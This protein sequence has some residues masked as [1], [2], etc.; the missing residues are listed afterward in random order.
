[1]VEGWHI[2]PGDFESF[3]DPWLFEGREI[4]LCHWGTGIGSNRWKEAT[5][6]FLF[7]EFHMP[8]RVHQAEVFALTNQRASLNAL[9]KVQSPNNREAAFVALRD[10]H[11]LRWQKQL[12]M[13]GNARN[14]TPSGVCG[15]QKLVITGEFDR[16]ISNKDV[17]FPGAKLKV[18]RASIQRG[19]KMTG[20]AAV[21]AMLAE[22]KEDVIPSSVVK[23][24]TGVDMGKHGKRIL[25]DA[26]L[27]GVMRELGWTW[28]PTKGGKGH[29]S[30]FRR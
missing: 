24:R 23:E 4:A 15:K 29:V 17:L 8:S 7:G 12:A 19:E 26:T 20:A 16:F 18:D 27:S 6:V 2:A 1:M 25:A 28:A 5:A 22:A 21:A 14:I 3:D 30:S 13:R 11:L 10:G 9:E